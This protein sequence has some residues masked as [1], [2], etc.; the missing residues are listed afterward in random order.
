MHAHVI[1]SSFV[2]KKGL[3]FPPL[4]KFH[5]ED[6]VDFE[7]EEEEEEESVRVETTVE[8]LDTFEVLEASTTGSSL[9]KEGQ[10]GAEV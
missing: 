3:E 5:L 6:E 9:E 7:N 1:L 10:G 2:C 4:P 8:A